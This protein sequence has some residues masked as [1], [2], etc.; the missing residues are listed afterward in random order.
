MFNP[1]LKGKT[2]RLKTLDLLKVY[3]S[4]NNKVQIFS[5]TD[6]NELVLEII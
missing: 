3:Q 5:L 6:E 1:F 2:I 4:L